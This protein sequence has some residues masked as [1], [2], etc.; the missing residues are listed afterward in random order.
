MPLCSKNALCILISVTWYLWKIS[1]KIID[2]FFYMCNLIAI[3]TRL[4]ESMLKWKICY[5]EWHIIVIAWYLYWEY[6]ILEVVLQMGTFQPFRWSDAVKH[7]NNKPAL[8]SVR[9]NPEGYFSDHVACYIKSG[10]H[11]MDIIW[12][13]NEKENSYLWCIIFSMLNCCKV[14]EGRQIEFE[15]KR[16]LIDRY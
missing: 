7:C 16:N 2:H 4:S 12:F 10:T 15:R 9:S 5:L 3:L 13:Q 11:K 14:Q 6:I 8:N 1:T